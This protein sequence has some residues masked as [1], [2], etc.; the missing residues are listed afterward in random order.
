VKKLSDQT[1][2]IIAAALSLI[3]I[4]G[5]SILYKPTPPPNTPAAQS[6][7]SNSSATAAPGAPA[8]APAGASAIA[9]LL[10]GATVA[11]AVADTAEKTIVVESDLYRVE[12]SNRGAVVR[13]W[14]LKKFSD[15]NK[16]P[17]TLDLVNADAALQ[18]GYW[19]FSLVLG[20]T[21]LDAA[22][23]QGLYVVTPTGVS[24]GHPAN[25]TLTA[26]AELEFHWSNGQLDV[27]KKLKFDNS[28]IAAIETDVRNN[29][30]PLA[31]SIAWG[32]GFGDA[33]A[34][35]AAPTV[36]YDV[37]G[38]VTALATKNLGDA[39]Q[40]SR[41]AVV[42]GTFDAVGIQDL[43]FAAAFLPSE[44]PDGQAPPANL[45]VLARQ[46]EHEIH[47]NNAVTKEIL[48]EMAAGSTDP[49]PLA[50]RVF[51]GP[52]DLD[53]LKSVRPPLGGL[54][55]FGW[56][57]FIAEPLFYSLRWLH[58]YVPNY[59]WAIVLM[60]IGINMLLYPLKLKSWRSMQKMQKVAPEIRSIQDR[61]KKYTM[62]DPRKAEMNKE[63]MSVYSREGIN[64]MGS[65]LPML[66]QFPIW[67]GL[68]SMLRATIELRHA[69]WFGWIH[70][71]SDRDPYYVLPIVMSLLMYVVQKMT[72]T[73]VTDPSQQ[74]M[75]NLMPLAFS[76]MFII[77]PFSSGLVLY[78]LTSNIIAVIQQWH[79]NRTSPLKIPGKGK[80]K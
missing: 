25:G 15:E 76:A 29:G 48:P 42:P 14:Q 26:P 19:P 64:P 80:K 53:T 28:Y 36:F 18:T 23:N 45:T 2:A 7:A 58:K 20:N 34:Y 54:V 5:W 11:A 6:A 70:D 37:G 65:C 39:N 46:I 24:V 77:Y 66:V 8:T 63:V 52:K 1:R 72:P 78:I 51:V 57:A 73:T 30:Q 21:Q 3:V 10:K 50:E 16:P 35:R 74:R 43:Y 44:P 22:A 62:R 31:N 32:G 38:K 75:M 79:L 60:T 55:Q 40:R 13:S 4:M 59:G 71:L 67:F 47:L 27:T 17:R 56:T 41:F 68:N 33:T 9:S 61:Y 12:I 49:D 69:P